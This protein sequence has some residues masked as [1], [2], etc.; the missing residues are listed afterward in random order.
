M[1]FFKALNFTSSNEDGDT[2]RRALALAPGDRVVCLT[3][4]GTRP[5]D[6][7]A[8]DVGEVVALDL[9]PAQNHLLALKA[10]ALRGLDDRDLFVFLGLGEGDR[11][12]LYA[13]IRR[14]LGSAKREFW[15]RRRT[16]IRRGI[17]YAGRWE[18]VLRFGAF[19]TRILRG[20]RIDRLFA[21]AD[22]EEQADI[23]ARHFDDAIWH[24]AIRLLS[25]PW[26]WRDVIG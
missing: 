1:S 5:L 12:A 23:W 21:A 26:F 4:S 17:W 25:A 2:E 10:A 19:G 15:D 9:N 14:H 8:D 16:I 7:L 22:V 24:W 3:A 18:Q 20:D 11:E 6:L 13:R